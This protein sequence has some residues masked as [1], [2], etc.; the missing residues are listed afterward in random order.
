[1]LDKAALQLLPLLVASLPLLVECSLQL[2][3]LALRHGAQ[4][5]AFSMAGADLQ[6]LAWQI[7]KALNKAGGAVFASLA[8]SLIRLAVAG[9]NIEGRG[10][11]LKTGID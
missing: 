9:N 10:R 7:L 5:Q 4:T 8:D 1:M 11:A 2:G 3:D 6:N